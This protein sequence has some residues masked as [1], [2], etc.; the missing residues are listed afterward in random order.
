MFSSFTWD[1]ITDENGWSLKRSSLDLSQAFLHFHSI[2]LGKAPASRVVE[3]AEGHVERRFWSLTDLTDY[4]AAAFPAGLLSLAPSL[5]PV[6]CLA[7]V[8]TIGKSNG[9][10]QLLSHQPQGLVET[11]VEINSTS[12]T[13]VYLQPLRPPALTTSL[14]G[15]GAD[16]N[17][18]NLSSCQ[19]PLNA[20]VPRVIVLYMSPQCDKSLHH[21]SASSRPSRGAAV[22]LWRVSSGRSWFVAM[23]NNQSHP[24]LE[25]KLR[26]V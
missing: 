8:E 23:D 24:T 16:L 11:R 17:E 26:G 21:L 9:T 18:L 2:A 14:S 5:L 12:P 13:A 22:A 20:H 15:K 4:Q 19:A 3:T 7:C 1:E 10:T 25:T 6:P